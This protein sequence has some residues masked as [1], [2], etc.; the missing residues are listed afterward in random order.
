[1][2]IFWI[3]G[4]EK[5]LVFS[6]WFILS[7]FSFSNHVGIRK[8]YLILHA[9]NGFVISHCAELNKYD[10]IYEAIFKMSVHAYLVA[11]CKAHGH[12]SITSNGRGMPRAIRWPTPRRVLLVLTLVMMHLP[13]KDNT[14]WWQVIPK[15]GSGWVVITTASKSTTWLT[16]QWI[17]GILSYWYLATGGGGSG[18]A[19]AGESGLW[20]DED[21]GSTWDQL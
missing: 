20:D 13:L 12:K 4:N 10:H 17:S 1:M 21:G 14:R 8:N 19:R 7:S 11:N 16:G 3:C 2:H 6:L 5:S 15:R 9:H 18:P